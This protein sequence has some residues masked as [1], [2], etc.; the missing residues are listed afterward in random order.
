[1]TKTGK[2]IIAHPS[3]IGT[4]APDPLLAPLVFDS[5]GFLDSLGLKKRTRGI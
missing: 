4:T 3:Q 2:A 1:M 5:P